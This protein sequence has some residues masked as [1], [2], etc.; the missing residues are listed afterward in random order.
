MGEQRVT[1]HRVRAGRSE[2]RVVRAAPG[3]GRLALRDEYHWLTL[4]ADRAGLSRLLAMWSLAARSP[5]TLLHLPLRG[6]PMPAGPSTTPMYESG[7]LALDLVLAHH[8]LQFRPAAWKDV[9][10]R[11]GTGRP[12]TTGTPADDFLAEPRS[13]GRLHHPTSATACASRPPRPWRRRPP[14]R[15][16]RAPRRTRPGALPARPV[17]PGVGVLNPRA[18]SPRST[19]PPGS[20]RPPGGADRRPVRA[21]CGA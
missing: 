5:R 1:V 6:Q 4:Y 7:H 12:R 16:R 10:S 8:S 18:R 2:Y 20:T 11:L 3:P 13:A 21:S 14:P 9:R 15:V 17:L 19:G